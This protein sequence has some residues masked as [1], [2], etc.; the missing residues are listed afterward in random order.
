MIPESVLLAYTDGAGERRRLRVERV[1]DG[2]ELLEERHDGDAWVGCG[3]ERVEGVWLEGEL[4]DAFGERT[5]DHW[6]AGP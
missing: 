4:H 5:V 2:W 1:D 6:S 3:T